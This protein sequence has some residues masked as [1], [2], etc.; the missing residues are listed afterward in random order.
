MIPPQPAPFS[1]LMIKQT[2]T[3]LKPR[4]ETPNPQ[5]EQPQQD[6]RGYA[7]H[8][9][10]THYPSVMRF[11]KYPRQLRANCKKKPQSPKF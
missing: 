11:L 3:E 2:I 6:Q 8:P 1:T 10:T 5:P 7:R 9:Y 4:V